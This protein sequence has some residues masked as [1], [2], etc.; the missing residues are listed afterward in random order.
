MATPTEVDQEFTFLVMLR[1]HEMVC[2]GEDVVTLF[3]RDRE[4]I[5][6]DNSFPDQ[7]ESDVAARN[8][9]LH[10]THMLAL[11]GCS[12]LRQVVMTSLDKAP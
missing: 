1:S 8:A 7:S 4:A 11:A 12:W 10:I 9:S 2:I 6:W 5:R 3:L